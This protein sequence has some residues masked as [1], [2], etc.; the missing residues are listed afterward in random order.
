MDSSIQ[1][2]HVRESHIPVLS[3]IFDFH[4]VVPN[5]VLKTM[6]IVCR[7]HRAF[8]AFDDSDRDLAQFVEPRGFPR[9]DQF[10]V[11]WPHDVE[12]KLA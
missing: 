12:H 7:V 3:G 2:H 11:M 4:Q 8:K 1:S 9:C 5:L 10:L 6:G